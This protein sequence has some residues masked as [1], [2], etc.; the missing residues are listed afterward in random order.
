[1]EPLDQIHFINRLAFRSW[2]EKNHLT[3]P[4]IWMMFFK[5]QKSVGS[6]SYKEALEEALCFGWI[7]SIV[8]KIDD[9]R[10]LRKFTPRTNTSNWSEVNKK[11][12]LTLIEKGQMTEAGLMKINS[13]RQ[14]G[15]VNWS[16][17][18]QEENVNPE[19]PGFILS[20]LAENEPALTNFKNLAPSYQQRYIRWISQA[21]RDDTLRRR[22]RES[23]DL[24]KKNIKLGLK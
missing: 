6:I 12:V 9:A 1:M 7:D 21:K 4:G 16:F 24:L 11:L 14:T 18:Q 19:V 5:T 22:L 8:K 2:L 20:A 13:Y 17:R 10:Y 23:I 3:S 15:Q